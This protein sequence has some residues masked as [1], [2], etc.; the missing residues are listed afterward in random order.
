M[1]ENVNGSSQ[2]NVDQRGR[3]MLVCYA[4]ALWHTLGRSKLLF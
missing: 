1:I 2:K 3:S 4:G